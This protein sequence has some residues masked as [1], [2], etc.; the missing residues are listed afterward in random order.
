MKK[1]S[2][3]FLNRQAELF[4]SMTRSGQTDGSGSGSGGEQPTKLKLAPVVSVD[5]KKDDGKAKPRPKAAIFGGADEDEEDGKKKKRELIR[6]DYS[7]DEDEAKKAE[8]KKI[9][10]QE[11][12]SAIPQDKES[13]WAYPI[14][15]EKLSEVRASKAAAD[16]LPEPETRPA[17]RMVA[18]RISIAPPS[19]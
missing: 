18:F 6:L 4:A 1:E 11:L 19:L 17:E 14:R 10:V 15:W 7:D 3:D 5:A 16:S 2:E 9:K 13:L 12:V 8:K